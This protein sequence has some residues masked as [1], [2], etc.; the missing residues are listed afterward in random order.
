MTKKWFECSFCKNDWPKNEFDFET[1][2]CVGCRKYDDEKPIREGR[3]K[4]MEDFK[5]EYP[6]TNFNYVAGDPFW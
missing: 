3:F 1:N 4:R 2:Q 6:N 5:K